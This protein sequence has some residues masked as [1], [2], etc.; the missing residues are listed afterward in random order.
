MNSKYAR[1]FFALLLGLSKE[2]KIIWHVTAYDLQINENGATECL[3]QW[4]CS[5]NQYVFTVY[6]DRCKAVDVTQ[7]GASWTSPQGVSNTVGLPSDVQELR[8]WLHHNIPPNEDD[9]S[10]DVIKNLVADKFEE[11]DS[12]SIEE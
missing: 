10:F 11:Y 3:W 5:F 9:I 8:N 12:S 7:V 1:K 4:R 6:Q 2:Q